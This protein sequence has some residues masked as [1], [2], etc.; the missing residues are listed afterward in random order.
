VIRRTLDG[1]ALSSTQDALS[2]VTAVMVEN[3][4]ESWPLSGLDKASV[5]YEALAEGRI[6]RFMALF[7]Y[8]TEVE[9]LGPVR[10]ARPYYLELASP[11]NAVYMHVGGS[12]DALAYLKKLDL[13]DNDQF[14]WS[15]YFW[16]SS[17][18]YAPHNVYT[19][20]DLM[21]KMYEE[22][23]IDTTGFYAGWK[24]DDSKEL[25]VSYPYDIIVNYTDSTYQAKYI[26]NSELDLYQRYQAKEPMELADGSLIFANTVIIQEHA[27]QVLDAVG[28]RAIEIVGEG[29]VWIFAH[30]KVQEGVWKKDDVE[31]LTR[32]YTTTGEEISI[33][34]GKIWINVVEK[35]SFELMQLDQ[36]N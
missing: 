14:F 3:N 15:Q 1:V 35:D 19:S 21:L 7:P 23:E 29:K 28:R 12:P 24:F 32:Y 33:N 13:I 30:G 26:Y 9:K 27:H 5:V 8:G 36:A 18:R 31:S 2:H 34:P 22:R 10:S 25:G 20:S 16:R 4:F 11:F 17:D 6:P